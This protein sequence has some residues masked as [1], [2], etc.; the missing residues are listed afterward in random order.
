M[1]SNKTF[2][3]QLEEDIKTI[4]GRGL[5][6]PARYFWRYSKHRHALAS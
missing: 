6:E 5:Q 3:S 1:T 2:Y 4:Y